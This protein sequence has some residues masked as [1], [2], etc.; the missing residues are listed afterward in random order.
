MGESNLHSPAYQ[1]GKV[2]FFLKNRSKGHRNEGV[3]KED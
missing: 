3:N 2:P 1:R